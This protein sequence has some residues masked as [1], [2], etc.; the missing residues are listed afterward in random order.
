MSEDR[1]KPQLQAERVTLQD[2]KQVWPESVIDHNDI[3]LEYFFESDEIGNK[4][5]IIRTP[6]RSEP[7]KN[8][9]AYLKKA[10]LSGSWRSKAQTEG[11]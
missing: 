6:D 9:L 4:T 8:A 10:G 11:K 5:M 7:Y 3:E 2:I 1:E